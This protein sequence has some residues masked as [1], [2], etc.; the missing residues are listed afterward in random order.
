MSTLNRRDFCPTFPLL[1]FSKDA[2]EGMEE[3]RIVVDT[4]WPEEIEQ[5][6]QVST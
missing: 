5:P 2:L 4:A 6:S 3:V 1:E